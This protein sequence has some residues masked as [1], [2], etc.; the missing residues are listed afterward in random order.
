MWFDNGLQVGPS[1]A[2][3]TTFADNTFGFL[4]TVSW[5]RGK[6]N[7]KFGGG[8]TGYQNNTIYDYYINGEFDF[9]TSPLT[10]MVPRAQEIRWRISCL[11][12]PSQLFQSPQ[13]P[14]NIRSKAMNVFFQDEW[15]VS[16]RFTVT[17]GLRY[18][19]S[20]PKLD[21]QGRSFSIVPGLQ[22][23]VFT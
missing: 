8:L 15:H 19:Y 14:S 21:T 23:T 9:Y 16:R 6:H 12:A 5:I 1:E 22:S 17:L 7:F 18:E 2:G 13:A 3:P 10:P 4:D 11:G 20:Q